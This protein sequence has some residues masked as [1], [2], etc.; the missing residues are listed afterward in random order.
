MTD[1]I[2]AEEVRQHD[3]GAFLLRHYARLADAFEREQARLARADAVTGLKAKSVAGLA[4]GATY[5][6]LGLLLWRGAVPLA[7][8]GTAVLAIR[9][10]T[11]QLDALV[12]ALN[13]VFE[14][15]LYLTDWQDAI[16]RADRG[17]IPDGGVEPDGPPRVIRAEGLGFKYPNASGPALTGVDVE[18][19]AGQIVAL[20]GENGSGKTTLAKLLTGLYLPSEGRVL[21]DGTSTADL[22]R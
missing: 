1:K 21:W 4:T 6:L 17:R 15:G 16:D 10:G 13:Q 9:T 14:Y 8:A 20:V 12:R 3:A 7:T 18:I 11:A 19:R 2:P 22:A 5:A